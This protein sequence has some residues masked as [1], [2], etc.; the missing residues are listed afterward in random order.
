MSNILFLGLDGGA[1]K[2]LAQTCEFN[3]KSS[4]IIPNGKHIEYSYNE[5]NN[6]EPTFK[7][8]RLLQQQKEA[9]ENNYKFSKEEIKQSSSINDT[10][11]KII[12]SSL[13]NNKIAQIGLC[14]PGIKTKNFDGISIMVNGPRN[15]DML[16]QLNQ[17]IK[18]KLDHRLSIKTIY[19]DSECCV[20]GEKMS[21]SG[22]LKNCDNA[23]YIGGGTGIADG[24]ILNNKLIDLKNNSEIK[25]SWELV[26]PEGET[27]EQ[28]LSLGGMVSK[29]NKKK[30]GSPNNILSLFEYA[31]SGNSIANDILEKAAN[32]FTFL[33][34]DRTD[35]FYSQNVKPEKIVIGQRLGNLLSDK[36]N[37]L[38]KLISR[39]YKGHIPIEISTDRR[40]AAIG[41]AYKAH[42]NIK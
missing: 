7:P 10:I 38:S 6:F 35:F 14:F 9:N 30:K 16:S 4:L 28:C 12:L 31:A 3:P 39:N 25:R 34:N 21:S 29:W 32:A 19:D 24:L 26:T 1:T 2:V 40:T 42:E 27:I 33:I 15:I 17:K 37:P 20:I 41:A 22:K 23:I 13:K 36:N 8:T 18:S 5:S 11:I